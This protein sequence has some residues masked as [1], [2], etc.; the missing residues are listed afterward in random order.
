MALIDFL[1]LFFAILVLGGL[2]LMSR[3]GLPQQK[4]QS[5]EEKRHPKQ[6]K[7]FPM[8]AAEEFTATQ[9]RPLI[10][11]EER[12]APRPETYELPWTHGESKIVALARDPYWIFVYWEI[13]QAK[14]RELA[15]RFGPRAWEE[16][17]P[18]LR[19]YDTTN[20]YFFDS[21]DYVEIPINDYANNWYIHTGEPN[22][23]FC[24][25]LGRVLPDGTYIFIARSNFVSTPR[26]RVSEIVDEEWL[27][28]A[29]YEKRLY[30]RIGRVYPGPSSPAL[31]GSPMK[32]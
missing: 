19:V 18:V 23:T 5:P 3:K 9:P 11:K 31:I 2:S 30:E 25:E 24:V 15:E 12:E 14:R 26:D 7:P 4:P 20:L 21:R 8:E 22:K 29:E 16:S 32:W 13:S 1:L 6:Q 27:L 28:L 17:R 10:T